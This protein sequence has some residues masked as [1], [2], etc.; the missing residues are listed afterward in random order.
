MIEVLDAEFVAAL[1]AFVTEGGCEVRERSDGTPMLQRF[2][3]PV[4]GQFPHMLG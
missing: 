2:A 3:Q 1:R 4:N